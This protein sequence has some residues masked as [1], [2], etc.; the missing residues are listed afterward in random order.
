MTNKA[1]QVVVVVAVFVIAL[2]SLGTIIGLLVNTGQLSEYSDGFRYEVNGSKVTIVSYEGSDSDV[3]VPDKLKG[4]RVVGIAKDAFSTSASI[5]KSIK[6]NCTY[7]S[8]S[9]ANE[10]FAKLTSLEK[11]VLPTNL[12]TISYGAFEGCT[13]LKSVIIPNSVTIIEDNAF[14][15]C[16]SLNFIYS[17]DNY[18]T[19]GDNAIRN[20]A[21]YLP[22]SLLEI[23]ASA[24]EDCSAIANAYISKD[25]EKIGEKAFN[26]CSNLTGLVVAD[27]SEITSIGDY[28]FYNTTISSSVSTP[29]SFPNLVTIGAYAF[30]SVNTTYFTYM[31]LPKTVT[32]IGE[33]AFTECDSLSKFV[34]AEDT[35][36][37][38]MGEG[39][40]KGCT[41]LRNITLPTDIKE[42]PAKT[43]MG[44]YR[45][46]YGDND[47]VIGKSVE[48][49]GDG[50]FALYVGMGEK[51]SPAD[52]MRHVITVDEENEHFAIIRLEDSRIEGN[53]NST[54][55]QGLLTD[56]NG[57]TIYAYYGSYDS[58]SYSPST[59]G[60][61]FRLLDVEGRTV[62][63]VTTVKPYAFAGVK[64]DYIELPVTIK[65]LGEYA[66]YKS[67]VT[68]FYTSAIDWEF[69]ENTFEK[70][71]LNL[72]EDKKL[73][74]TY[75]EMEVLLLQSKEGVEAFLRKLGEF[76]I[77]AGTY[78]GDL[79]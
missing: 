68:T 66:F 19:E 71:N 28:A 76:G 64:F 50:A 1:R 54:Y 55:R 8:F 41:G 6:F 75:P 33:Y 26:E 35:K 21:L 72:E 47:F 5:V 20:N 34:M 51:Q 53:S 29:L 11:V 48:S 77:R 67:H 62:Q 24:F 43:F 37:E 15:G 44:C 79:S 40:F 17:S 10:A 4:H 58:K 3:V 18:S 32:S 13:S 69:T 27:G 45:L 23:G 52:F 63:S 2:A 12:K 22:T 60:K 9:I 46:L 7:S 42:I 59:N 39:V 73:V 25:L 38:T 78:S 31:E 70:L 14:K 36:I 56:T 74:G 16:T 30:G 65:G 61:T 49:I 57:T